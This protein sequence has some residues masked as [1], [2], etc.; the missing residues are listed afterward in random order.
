MSFSKNSN[1]KIYFFIAICMIVILA[2]WLYTL[3]LNL[4]KSGSLSDSFRNIFSGFSNDAND[5]LQEQ[6]KS[7]NN[8][9]EAKQDLIN[10]LADELKKNE[11]EINTSSTASSTIEF[12]EE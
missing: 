10:K 1:F 6:E 4:S 3:K 11:I 9:L 12:L 5:I 8:N 2:M 7:N